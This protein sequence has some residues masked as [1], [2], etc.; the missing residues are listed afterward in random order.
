M[1][2]NMPAVQERKHQGLLKEF[3][4][5]LWVFIDVYKRARRKS[6]SDSSRSRVGILCS[7]LPRQDLRRC[8][9]FT[10]AHLELRQAVSHVEELV[11][12]SRSLERPWRM[13]WLLEG[14]SPAPNARLPPPLL[15]SAVC[16]FLWCETGISQQRNKNH[17]F[18]FLNNAPGNL[19]PLATSKNWHKTGSGPFECPPMQ[20]ILQC[21]CSPGAL[22]GIILGGCTMGTLYLYF[23]K[24]FFGLFKWICSV[25]LS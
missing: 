14:R 24:A 3:T 25:I 20:H 11:T 2:N 9:R 4:E 18:Q 6:F 15:G 5:G 16:A 13:A 19:W 21:L 1:W 23:W 8:L 7:S 10:L 12:S 17:C 22:L